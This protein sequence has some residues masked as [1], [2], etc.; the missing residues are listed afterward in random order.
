MNV[1]ELHAHIRDELSKNVHWANW[2]KIKTVLRFGRKFTRNLLRKSRQPLRYWTGNFSNMGDW[3]PESI[4]AGE[5]E[6]AWV[7]APPAFTDVAI[8]SVVIIWRGR[9]CATFIVHPGIKESAAK[10]NET[11]NRWRENLLSACRG[12]GDSVPCASPTPTTS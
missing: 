6:V 8:S 2:W 1:A 4:P 7:A 3:N 10:M 12:D 5:E 11:I 9:V